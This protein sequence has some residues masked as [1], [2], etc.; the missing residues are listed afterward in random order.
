MLR[1]IQVQMALDGVPSGLSMN[2]CAWLEEYDDSSYAFPP[3]IS[4]N[5]RSSLCPKSHC[6]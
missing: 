2:G 6:A 4:A 1:S 3:R 5:S